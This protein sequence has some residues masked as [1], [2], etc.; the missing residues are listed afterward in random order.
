M[1]PLP[2]ALVFHKSSSRFFH[3]LSQSLPVQNFPSRTHYI[4]SFSNYLSVNREINIV[5]NVKMKIT[6]NMNGKANMNAS[7]FGHEFPN[8]CDEG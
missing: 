4:I 2:T 1:Y 3:F 5:I 6:T 8:E 7:E